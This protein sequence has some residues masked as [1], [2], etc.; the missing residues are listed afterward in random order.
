MVSPDPAIP[1][2]RVGSCPSYAVRDMRK[3]MIPP[4]HRS[5]F[6]ASHREPW[7]VSSSSIRCPVRGWHIPSPLSSWQQAIL[8]PHSHTY[9]LST[10]SPCRFVEGSCA[11]LS[12]PSAARC[13][14]FLSRNLK[15]GSQCLFRLLPSAF[16]IQLSQEALTSYIS[17]FHFLPFLL[18][19]AARGLSWWG[20]LVYEW[21]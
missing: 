11:A 16:S 14:C 2:K 4:D 9:F 6:P 8:F 5:G 13:A 18:W 21:P 20:F 12:S 17:R 19:M 10:A 15:V 1:G 3:E 7:E